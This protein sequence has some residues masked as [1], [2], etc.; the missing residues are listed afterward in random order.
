MIFAVSDGEH[1]I[2]RLK[3]QFMLSQYSPSELETMRALKQFFDP[4]LLLG[5]GV[6]FD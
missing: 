6:L 1:G 5:K 4:E 2:G 3:K